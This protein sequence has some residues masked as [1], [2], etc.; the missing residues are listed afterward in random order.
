MSATDTPVAA[1]KPFLD[2]LSIVM[3]MTVHP[4]WGGQR[5]LA[6]RAPKIAEAKRLLRG[7]AI[8]PTDRAGTPAIGLVNETLA[9]RMWPEGSAVGRRGA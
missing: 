7:R 2:A 8:E 4:G 9:R 5:F 6:D 1:V 3:I